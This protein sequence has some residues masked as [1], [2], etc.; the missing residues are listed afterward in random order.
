MPERGHRFYG[1]TTVR[2]SLLIQAP[3]RYVYD[4]CTDYRS[5]DGRLSNA[6]PRP[7]FHVIRIS[8][9]RVVRVRVGR[10]S[11]RDPALTVERIRLNPPRSWHQDQLDETDQQ[12][13]DYRVRAVGR[14]RT[15]F[16]LLSTERWLTPDFPTREALRAQITATWTRF[17]AAI[18]A[19]YR[20]GR[21]AR[22]R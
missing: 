16:Q 11:G 7:K 8:P 10:G 4:W 9:R 2:V 1:T 5:D 14:A 12:S 3:S 22:G 21:P 15:R 17:A 6:R 18:E 19:D 20:A 13:V